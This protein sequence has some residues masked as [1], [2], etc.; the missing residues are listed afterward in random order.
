MADAKLLDFFKNGG[1]YLFD[2]EDPSSERTFYKVEDLMGEPEGEDIVQTEA[3][4]EGILC[5][6]YDCSV[7]GDEEALEKYA[8]GDYVKNI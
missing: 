2:E 3:D 6:F 7:L 4:E 8:N 5:I 1:V